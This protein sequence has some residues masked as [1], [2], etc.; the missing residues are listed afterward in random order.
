M[1]KTR[2]LNMSLYNIHLQTQVDCSCPFARQQAQKGHSEPCGKQNFLL[3]KKSKRGFFRLPPCSLITMLTTQRALPLDRHTTTFT[4][5]CC[6]ILRQAVQNIICNSTNCSKQMQ[7]NLKAVMSILSVQYMCSHHKQMK[8]TAV[9]AHKICCY[10]YY[11]VD[12]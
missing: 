6:T 2:T 9:N 11:E 12:K 7:L 4:S 8:Q 10:R 1:Y 5:L 3:C